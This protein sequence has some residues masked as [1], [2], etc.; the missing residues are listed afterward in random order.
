MDEAHECVTDLRASIGA[1]EAGVLAVQDRAL[2]CLF[3]VVVVERGAG[4]DPYFT[5]RDRGTGIGLYTSKTIIETSVR[6]RIEARNSG[7]GA[8]FRVVPPI[9]QP[10]MTDP[11]RSGSRRQDWPVWRVGVLKEM[12]ARGCAT[13]TAARVIPPCVRRDKALFL[14]R[15]ESRPATSASA[16]S[17]QP[18]HRLNRRRRSCLIGWSCL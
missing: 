13:D 16:G 18:E 7:E 12:F 10:V 8:E 11:T 5:T 17:K 3:D 1:I 9:A 14:R 2:Q 15:R 6:G 4:F